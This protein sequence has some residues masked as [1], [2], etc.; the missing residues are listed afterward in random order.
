MYSL[1]SYNFVPMNKAIIF[2]TSIIAQFICIE[3][4]IVRNTIKKESTVPFQVIYLYK[5]YI[6][7]P[8][9]YILTYK[10]SKTKASPLIS[11]I[12]SGKSVCIKNLVEWTKISVCRCKNSTIEPTFE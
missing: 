6:I 12:I 4:I 10:K 7:F 1:V 3:Y 8:N 2:C 5:T 9:T 11:L